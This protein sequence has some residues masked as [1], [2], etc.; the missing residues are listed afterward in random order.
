MK[1]A[2]FS[3]LC[4]FSERSSPCYFWLP[5]H[6]ND[7]KGK[8]SKKLRS[9]AASTVPKCCVV[10][11]SDGWAL[12]PANIA[13]HTDTASKRIHKLEQSCLV[14]VSQFRNQVEHLLRRPAVENLG[15]RRSGNASFVPPPPTEMMDRL[16]RFEHFLHDDKHGLPLFG[17]G[18]SRRCTAYFTQERHFRIHVQQNALICCRDSAS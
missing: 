8:S 12:L 7:V 3:F 4:I 2:Q 11:L 14:A 13:S 15:L 6:A 18:R 16:N 5:L 10:S 1:S 9:S 17:R